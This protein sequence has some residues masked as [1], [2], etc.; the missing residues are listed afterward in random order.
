MP[1]MCTDVHGLSQNSIK[2][3]TEYSIYIVVREAAQLFY[4]IFKTNYHP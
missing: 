2:L 1:K 3:A 4:P